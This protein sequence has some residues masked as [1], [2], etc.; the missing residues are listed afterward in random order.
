MMS[1]GA[2]L[3]NNWSSMLFNNTTLFDATAGNL[4]IEILY[5]PTMTV[6]ISF[7]SESL[8]LKSRLLLS[9]MATGTPRRVREHARVRWSDLW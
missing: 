3:K 2:R 4:Q 6:L 8:P 9:T 7:K 1:T 5:S